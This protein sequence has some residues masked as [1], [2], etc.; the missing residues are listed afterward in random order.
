MFSLVVT[1]GI[2]IKNE[3]KSN[4][5]LWNEERKKDIQQ[6]LHNYSKY[7]YKYLVLNNCTYIYICNLE[8]NALRRKAFRRKTRRTL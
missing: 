8:Y 5:E 2:I 6:R 7:K 3:I 4:N 1:I